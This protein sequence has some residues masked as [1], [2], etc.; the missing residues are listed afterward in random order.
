MTGNFRRLI[1]GVAITALGIMVLWSI[2][3]RQPDGSCLDPVII[4]GNALDLAA[5]AAT[6]RSLGA[7]YSSVHEVSQQASWRIARIRAKSETSFVDS[8]YDDDP[9]Y[10]LQIDIVVVHGDEI[11]GQIARQLS[12][13]RYGR[14]ICP[15]VLDSGGPPPR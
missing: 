9:S 3:A 7:P 13:W 6:P 2:V 4:G 11:S 12:T 15:F 1:I 14:V 5:F 10:S 8:L